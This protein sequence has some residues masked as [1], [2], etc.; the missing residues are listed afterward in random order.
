L[1]SPTWCSFLRN[2]LDGIAAIDVFV[3]VTAAFRLLYVSVILRYARRMILHLN[4]TQHPTAEWL[5]Q[6]V[7][8]AFPWDAAP[9]YL[10]RDRDASYGQRFSERME[11]MGISEVVIGARAPWQNGY[12]ERVIGS[13][14]RECRTTSWSSTNGICVGFSRSTETITIVRALIFRSIRTVRRAGRCNFRSAGSSP[15]HNCGACIIGTNGSQR[16]RLQKMGF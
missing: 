6:Q 3:V 15:Y 4:V 5:S 10:V 12:V 13:I 2:Q 14:R 9:R 8:E 11:A 7:T 16:S 1:P